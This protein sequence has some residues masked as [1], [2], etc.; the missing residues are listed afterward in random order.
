MSRFLRSR[1]FSSTPGGDG[2]DEEDYS[3]RLQQLDTDIDNALANWKKCSQTDKER[4]QYERR[5]NALY[6]QRKYYKKKVMVKALQGQMAKLESKNRQVQ[7]QNESLEALLSWAKLQV[8][9]YELDAQSTLATLAPLS[10]RAPESL[11][12]RGPLLGTVV[13]GASLDRIASLKR[14]LDYSL[15]PTS[16]EALL[17][18]QRQQQVSSD[19]I[20]LRAHLLQRKREQLEALRL[21]EARNNLSFFQPPPSLAALGLPSSS[22]PPVQNPELQLLEKEIL[23]RRQAVVDRLQGQRPIPKDVPSQAFKRLRTT[24]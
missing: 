14:Q 17:A 12:S 13:P 8:E 10:T 4:L 1:I 22:L 2:D 7:A 21:L 11:L 19:G 15:P 16:M 20:L 23:L 18:Q 5:R 3:A 6:S 24:S 9:R